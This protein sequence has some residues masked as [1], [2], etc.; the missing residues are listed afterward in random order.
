MLCV[1]L[2]ERARLLKQRLN[3]K[4]TA[5]AAVVGDSGVPFSDS[6]VSGHRSRPR[7]GRKATSRSTGVEGGAVESG[8]PG[9]WNRME[10]GDRGSAGPSGRHTSR[11]T[12]SST[13]RHDDHTRRSHAADVHADRTYRRRGQ[14]LTAH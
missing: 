14:K 11:T 8:S 9:T 4:T 6:E 2:E 12:S 1:E 3:I 13:Y 10:S 5:A 7:D